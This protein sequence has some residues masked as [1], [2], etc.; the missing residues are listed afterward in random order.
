MSETARWALPLM[1][2]GQARKEMTHNEALALLDLLAGP[3]VEAVGVD[4]PPT[5][6]AVGQC[7]IVGAAPTGA[8]AGRPRALAGWTAGGWRFVPPREGLAAWSLADGCGVAF[9]GGAW[10]VGRLDANALFVGGVQVVGARGAP[11]AAPTGG[12]AP[13]AEARTAIGAILA[14]L[15]AHGLIAS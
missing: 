14:A 3:S 11:I 10:R 2:A 13:D 8:W 1:D 12:S 5:T 9:T 6:P 7:W 4:T 15:T